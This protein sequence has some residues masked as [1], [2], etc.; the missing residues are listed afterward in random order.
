[1][2]KDW[3]TCRSRWVWGTEAAEILGC[4]EEQSFGRGSA[5]KRCKSRGSCLLRGTGGTAKMLFILATNSQKHP[6]ITALFLRILYGKRIFFFIACYEE[7]CPINHPQIIL[8][9][10]DLKLI[11]LQPSL[12]KYFSLLSL[13]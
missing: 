5:R 8:N 3:I 12:L 1:M 11:S 2:E 13:P 4:F 10:I 7:L 9:F 6:L